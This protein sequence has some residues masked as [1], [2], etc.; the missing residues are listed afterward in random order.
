MSA[1]AGLGSVRVAWAAFVTV[2]AL[3]MVAASERRDPLLVWNTSES[4]PRGLYLFSAAAP[5]AGDFVI[6]WPPVDAAGLAEARGYL[7]RG[8]PLIKTMVAGPGDHVCAR[9]RLMHVNGKLAATRLHADQRGRPLPWWS[10][11]RALAPGEILLLGRASAESFDGRYFGPVP[12]NQ[13]IG[14]ARLLWAA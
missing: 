10:G 11:C 4:S 7:P 9:G 5:A 14:L 13:V 3:L 6:A 12:V 1:R 2:L 8:V